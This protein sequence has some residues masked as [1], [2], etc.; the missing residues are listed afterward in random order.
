MAAIVAYYLA[1]LAPSNQRK[2]EI[3]K[4]DITKYFKQAAYKLPTRPE[5]TLPNAKA[6]G[7][8]DGVGRGKYRLNPVGHNLVV[9]NLPRPSQQADSR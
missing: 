9:H 6:A 2:T 3:A 4:A 1:E 8:F 5:Q 7:Y